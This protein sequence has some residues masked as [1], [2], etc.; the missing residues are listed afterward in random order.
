MGGARAA[1]VAEW[2]RRAEVIR[3]VGRGEGSGMASPLLQEARMRR[4]LNLEAVQGRGGAGRFVH[5]QYIY[6]A[7]VK[8]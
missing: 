8:L 3:G 1:G 6:I 5:V 4:A 2:D 7:T